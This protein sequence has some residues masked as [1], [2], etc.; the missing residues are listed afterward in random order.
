LLLSPIGRSLPARSRR[1]VWSPFLDKYDPP[2]HKA[3]IFECRREPRHSQACGSVSG[4]CRKTR[5]RASVTSLARP[6]S[7]S[8]KVRPSDLAVLKLMRSSRPAW[9]RQSRGRVMRRRST[10][11]SARDRRKALNLR[12]QNLMFSAMR[13]VK[14]EA[15]LAASYRLSAMYWGEWASISAYDPKRT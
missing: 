5:L 11:S 9:R 13:S 6:S 8:G 14:A 7:V 1:F 10:P 3:G 12:A 4:A 2:L 15:R